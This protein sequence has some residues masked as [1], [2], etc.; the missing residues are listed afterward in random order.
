[1]LVYTLVREEFQMK[2]EQ[3]DKVMIEM[4]MY[5]GALTY[6]ACVVRWH[7]MLCPRES[8]KRGTLFSH[9]FRTLLKALSLYYLNIM[10]PI[11]TDLSIIVL[12]VLLHHTCIS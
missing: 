8:R 10:L 1:M 7:N 12:F 4:V 5:S 9:L 6:W 11:C 2:S 3:R